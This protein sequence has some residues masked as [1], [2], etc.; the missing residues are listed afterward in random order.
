MIT[1][2]RVLRSG[3]TVAVADLRAIYTWRTWVFTWLLRILCQVAFFALIGRLLHSPEQTR[4]LL[5]G[6]AVFVVTMTTTFVCVSAAW[7]RMSGTMPL[8]V[9]SP[10]PLILVFIGR[11]VNWLVDGTACAAISLLAL[12]PVFGVTMPW[13]STL[14]AV[15]IIVL[16][17]LSTYCFALVLAGFVL[18]RLEL[19]NLVGNLAFLSLMLLCGVQVPVSFLPRPLQYAAD[20]LPLTHGL[21]AIRLLLA[22]APAT[23]IMVQAALEGAVGIGWLSISVAVFWQLAEAGRRSGAIEF[24][25]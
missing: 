13:P 12:A 21:A 14:L 23:H 5:I 25:S 6:N 1:A 19:R 17:G 8:L 10:A 3:F 24:G 4:Y 11:S 7:E 15:P 20:A 22:N 9:A 18:R 2:A 16:I